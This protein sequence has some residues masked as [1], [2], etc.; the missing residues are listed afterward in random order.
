MNFFKN[1]KS[2]WKEEKN[3][4]PKMIFRQFKIFVVNSKMI[5]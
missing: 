5:N 2:N 4:R 1:E 3:K